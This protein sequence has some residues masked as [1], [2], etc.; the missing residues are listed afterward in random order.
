M[1]FLQVNVTVSKRKKKKKG[2]KPAVEP[3]KKNPEL[4]LEGNRQMNR[5]KKMQFKK[6][7]KQ[8]RRKE[9]VALQLSN[10]L[11]NVRFVDKKDGGGDG[12]DYDF[13]EDFNTS[14]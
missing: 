8:Q 10:G 2:N 7:K 9:T 1:L 14:T 13:G 3:K 6:D 5:V 11:E 12:E 4:E